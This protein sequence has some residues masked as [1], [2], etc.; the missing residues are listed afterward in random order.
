MATRTATLRLQMIDAISGP[1]KGSS[2]AL[3]GLEGSINKLGRGGF[4]GAKNLVGQLEHLRRKSNE[5]GRFTELRRGLASTFGEFRSARARV[6]EL[7]T[8]L[9]TVTKPTGKMQADLRTARSNLKL[10]GDSFR[11][12]AAAARDSERGLRIFGLNSRS[13]IA[14]SQTEVRRQLAQTIRKMRELDREARKPL[15]ARAQGNRPGG[16]MNSAAGGV[17]GAYVA[18]GMLARPVGKALSY[19]ETLTYVATT[20]AGNGSLYAK[21]A[22]KVRVSN[23][24]DQALR[25]GGGTRESAAEALNALVSSGAFKD[26]EA[27]DALGPVLK[28][29]HA[30]GSNAADIANMAVAMRNNNVAVPDLQQG[31]DMALRGGQLG[32]FELRDMAR[33]FPQ[34][35]ALA[36]GAGLGGLDAVRSLTGLNQVSRA[37]AGTPDEAGNNLVNLLQKL[38]SR[39]L[40]K[41]MADTV[42]P[43]AGDPVSAD[44]EF[45]WSAYMVQRRQ[46]GLS[47][48]DALGEVLD[49]QVGNDAQYSEVMAK[50]ESSHNNA[51]KRMLLERAANIAENS[52]IGE[53]FADRQALMAALALRSEKTRRQNIDAELGRSGGTV[54]RESQFV[55]EQTWSKTKDL[56]NTADRANEGAYDALSGPL[57]SLVENVNEAART[58]PGLTSAL[59]GAGSALAALASGGIASSVIGGIVGGRLAGAGGRAA[60][61]GL[62]GGILSRGKSLASRVAGGPLGVG[63]AVAGGLSVADPEGNLWGLTSG[64]DKW[65]ERKTGINP[66][67]I[68]IA[69]KRSEAENIEVDLAGA[70]IRWPIAA[71]EGIRGYVAALMAGGA[72]AEQK[73]AVIGSQIE[74]ALSV[75]GSPTVNTADIEHALGLARQFAEIMRGLSATSPTPATTAVPPKLDGARASGGPVSGGKNYLVGEDGPEIFSPSRSGSIIPNHALGTG[76]AQSIAPVNIAVTINMTGTAAG[77]LER[78]A[79]AAAQKVSGALSGTLDRQLGRSAQI[80]FS[81]LSYGDA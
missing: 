81:G 24:V 9:A 32:S 14:N 69:R 73:A 2:K 53:V 5:I 68:Q 51:E 27:L 20:L 12:Q 6:K 70:T 21:R 23:A 47:A 50:L 4:K 39:E 11:E 31:F 16:M 1:A 46:Q 13:A 76:S 49:R 64:I 18:G 66:S 25:D 35:L 61:G 44:G 79:M 63:G 62:A 7:E 58:F 33:W 48:I 56:Q 57:G 71:Q 78:L 40:R 45:D 34:Q 41:T 72:E 38:N 37:T 15:P 10:M 77:D 43:K 54:E 19:D 26:E 60:A 28:T 17:A 67:N 80:T 75:N 52:A 29:A 22:A 36:R 30:S 3:G 42:K 59:Y 65:V 8:A 55:R 74:E